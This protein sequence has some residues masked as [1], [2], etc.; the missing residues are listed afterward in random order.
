MTPDGPGR[1]LEWH[2]RPAFARFGRRHPPEPWAYVKLRSGERRLL[3][4][5]EVALLRP[6]PAYP[7]DEE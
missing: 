6:G 7:E 1:L 4:G 2:V 5:S 3:R